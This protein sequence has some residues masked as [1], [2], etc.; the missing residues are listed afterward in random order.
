MADRFG[1]S[2]GVFRYRLVWCRLGRK[3]LPVRGGAAMGR[4]VEVTDTKLYVEERGEPSGFP[5]LVFHGG[6]GLDHTMFGDYLDP[7]TEDGRYRLVLAD[8][9]ACGRSDRAAPRGTWTLG[10]MAED[11]S[12]LAASLGVRDRYAT[13]GHSYGAFVVLQHAVDHP[14]Q[15]RGTIVSAGIAAARWLGE[16]GRQLAAFE[17]AHL[18][19]QV[20]S[21][22]ARETEVATEEEAA[23]LLVDQMPF[24]FRDPQG[25]ALAE[26][27]RRTAGL[28]RYAPEVIRHFAAQDYGGIDVE[29]RL[30]EVTHPVLVLAGRHDRACAVGASQDMARRLPDAQLV[31]FENAAH[32]TFAE[33]QDHYLAAVRQFLDRITN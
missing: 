3:L 25:A 21:S 11:V 27:L 8:E 2:P 20:T 14:G 16:V 30:G 6:P 24:H 13:L 31:V 5:L 10:R 7:L 4:L 22:W 32:M 1:G 29:D 17:P 26:Y 23:A 19:E 28:G 9:R 33:E 15:P 12:D 18:R